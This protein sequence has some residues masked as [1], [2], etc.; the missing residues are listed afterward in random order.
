MGLLVAYETLFACVFLTVLLRYGLLASVVMFTI[1][2]LTLRMPLTL[3]ESSLY[4]GAAWLTMAIVFALALAGV[5]MARGGEPM[6][7]RAAR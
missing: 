6:F 7:G 1:H 3:V 4:A 5:W 2:S